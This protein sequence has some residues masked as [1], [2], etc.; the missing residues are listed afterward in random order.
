MLWTQ[1]WWLKPGSCFLRTLHRKFSC[2]TVAKT[3]HSNIVILI[4]TKYKPGFSHQG[5]GSNQG[6]NTMYVVYAICTLLSIYLFD[7]GNWMFFLM[8]TIIACI[9]LVAQGSISF[10]I[11]D[12]CILRLVLDIAMVICIVTSPLK[13][14]HIK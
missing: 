9:Y 7:V 11:L 3:A 1:V 2:A 10:N 6:H 8:W 5:V 14:L 12:I 4:R 13:L